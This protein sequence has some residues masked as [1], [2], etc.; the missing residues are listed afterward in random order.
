MYGGISD[1]NSL[2]IQGAYE[3]F[4]QNI[5]DI[6]EAYKKSTETCNTAMEREFCWL[7]EDFFE[8]CEKSCHEA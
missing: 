2:I 7:F 1:F 8:V 4:L 3:K 6:F 5:L